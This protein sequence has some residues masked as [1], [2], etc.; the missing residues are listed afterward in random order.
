[1]LCAST[2]AG[3]SDGLDDLS[4]GEGLA[5]PGDAQQHLVR[6]AV[7]HAAREFLDGG[8]LIAL[9]AVVDRQMEA[10]LF[11]IVDSS[12]RPRGMKRA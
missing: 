5:G 11:S 3:P 9:A 2:S 4:H 1:M 7:A 6:L 10:H 12:R 8:L